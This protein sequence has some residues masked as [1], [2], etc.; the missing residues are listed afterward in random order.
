MLIGPSIQRMGGQEARASGN[1]QHAH[2]PPSRRGENG[3]MLLGLTVAVERTL[4]AA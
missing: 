3:A 2:L 1:A 4:E